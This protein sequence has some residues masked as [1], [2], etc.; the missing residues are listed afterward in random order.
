MAVIYVGRPAIL[1]ASS[2]WDAYTCVNQGLVADGSGIINTVGIYSFSNLVGC[3]IIILQQIDATHLT[4]RSFA[5]LA[6]VA[7][8]AERII[9]VDSVGNPLSLA[10]VAGDLIGIYTTTGIVRRATSGFDN[11]LYIAGDQSACS[12]KAFS[13]YAG[14]CISVYGTGATV[15][16]GIKWNGVTITKWNGQVITKLNGLP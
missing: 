5:S 11:M 1:R 15:A 10:V 16:A 7:S 3:K 9:T 14:D 12:N 2:V 4:A 13:T 6:E 8:G